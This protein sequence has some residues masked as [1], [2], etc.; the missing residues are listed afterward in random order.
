MYHPDFTPYVQAETVVPH[1][2]FGECAVVTMA[3]AMARSESGALVPVPVPDYPNFDTA[4]YMP[5]SGEP[6]IVRQ[7]FGD[8]DQA[9]AG[10]GDVVRLVEAGCPTEALS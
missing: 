7:Y 5:V 2:E 3:I 10:H 6:R 4:V 8:R 9:L 1:P